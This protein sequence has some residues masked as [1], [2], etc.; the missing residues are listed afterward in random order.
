MK[1]NEIIQLQGEGI[2]IRHWFDN[3]LTPK[4]W[5]KLNRLIE[6]ELL[7]EQECNK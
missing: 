2:E 1:K 4:Q 3:K 5:E 6:I 7:L